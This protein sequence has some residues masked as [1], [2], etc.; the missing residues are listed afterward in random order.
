MNKVITFLL[1]Y[2]VVSVANDVLTSGFPRP[3]I[4]GRFPVSNLHILNSFLIFFV[5]LFRHGIGESNTRI[6]HP[7][8]DFRLFSQNEFIR[9]IKADKSQ[10]HFNAVEFIFLFEQIHL[11]SLILLMFELFNREKEFLKSCHCLYKYLFD[12]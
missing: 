9:F 5:C 7:L 10:L 4:R 3:L 6:Q 8:S 2:I 12:Q 11:E 1:K